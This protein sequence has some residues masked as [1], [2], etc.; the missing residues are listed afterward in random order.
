MTEGPELVGEANSMPALVHRDVPLF[1]RVTGLVFVFLVLVLTT[2]LSAAGVPDAEVLPPGVSVRQVPTPVAT[3]MGT[4]PA[5]AR[6]E[7]LFTQSG[8]GGSWSQVVLPSGQIGFVP[9]ASLR[10]LT[11][12]PQWKSA[13]PG[14]SP[15]SIPSRAGGGFLDIPMRRA[16]GVFLVAVRLNNQITT[17][18]VVDTGASAVMISEALA[19]QLGLDYVNKPKRRTLTASGF[20]ESPRIVLD[21]IHVPDEGG[22]GVADVEAYVATLPGAPPAIGGLLGQSF[23][24]HFHVTIDA[25]RGV[26]HLRPMRQ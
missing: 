15:P 21:S 20:L 7:V 14:S 1:C 23:L 12:S 13:S 18:F 25:E 3:I 4:L 22:A 5:G 9:D 6:V 17:N 2:I 8:P 19:D 11:A 26:M 24:R 10:R 16:G